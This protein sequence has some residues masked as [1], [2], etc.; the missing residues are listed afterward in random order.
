MAEE[1]NATDNV[2]QNAIFFIKDLHL[3]KSIILDCIF[4][5]FQNV[6]L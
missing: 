3:K 1:K 6:A 2:L 4:L 5:C